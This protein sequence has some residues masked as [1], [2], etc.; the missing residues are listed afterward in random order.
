MHDKSGGARRDTVLAV[1]V[2]TPMANNG[3]TT[4]REPPG[5]GRAG[6]VHLPIP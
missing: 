2:G 6:S 3:E 4:T 5:R 1:V